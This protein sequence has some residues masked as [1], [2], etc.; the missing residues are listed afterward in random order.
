MV[1]TPSAIISSLRLPAAGHISW[2]SF[3]PSSIEIFWRL[4]FICTYILKEIARRKIVWYI[5]HNYIFLWRKQEK[6][7]I[8]K[9]DDYYKEIVHTNYI[10]LSNWKRLFSISNWYYLIPLYD[11]IFL[12]FL[13]NMIIYLFKCLLVKYIHTC[14][15]IEFWTWGQFHC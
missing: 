5:I 6:A 13:K 9:K 1:W 12:H 4:K 2:L 7:Y 3:R 14:I 11:T 15:L 10:Y 8:N